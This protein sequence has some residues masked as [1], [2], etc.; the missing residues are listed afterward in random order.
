M[1]DRSAATDRVA[2][3]ALVSLL[4]LLAAPARLVGEGGAAIAANR[5]YAM[6]VAD[7]RPLHGQVDH[8]ALA[9]GRRVEVWPR[10]GATMP[11]LADAIESLEEGFALW[12]PDDRLILCNRRYRD[13]YSDF[14]D[15]T[16]PGVPFL[17]H[18][19]ARMTAP[20][21]RMPPEQ[22]EA[23][24]AKRQRERRQNLPPFEVER[25]DG[26]WIR[27][28]DRT[29]ADGCLV[30]IRIDVTD[31][32]RGE[33]HAAERS[34]ILQATLENMNDGILAFDS[35][36]RLIAW[37]DKAFRL[38]GLPD[39][40]K[41]RGMPLLDLVRRQVA[42]GE[43][44][45]RSFEDIYRTH[46]E[47]LA[48]A[49]PES[50][51]RRRPDGT[52]LRVRHSSASN[53]GFITTFT[54]VTAQRRAEEEA[55]RH[56]AILAAVAAAAARILSGESWLDQTRLLL[57]RAGEVLAA[58][59]VVLTEIQHDE[60]GARRLVDVVVWSVPGQE[61]P[62]TPMPPELDALR[63]AAFADWWDR[64]ERGETEQALSRDLDDAKRGFLMRIGVRSLLRMPVLIGDHVWGTVGLDD[65]VVE[66]VWHPIEVE[67][68]RAVANLVGVAIN[69]ERTE[70][71]RRESD[72]T[73][74]GLFEA[75]PDSIVITE[76]QVIV[77]ANPI[78]V[79]MLG[80]T[81]ASELIGRDIYDFVPPEYH[82]IA[83]LR[84]RVVRE[85]GQPA[86]YREREMLRVDGS[87]FVVET[88]GTKVSA[89]GRDRLQLI[90][91]DVTEK[92]RAAAEIQR[93]REALLQSEKLA[94]LGSLLAGVAHELNNPLSVVV[95]Q[96]FLMEETA[97]DD[98]TRARAAKI[99]GAADRCARIVKTFLAMARQRP[100]ERR[101]VA[102]GEVVRDALEIVAYPLRTAG[103]EVAVTVPDDLPTLWADPDQLGQVMMNLLLNAQQALME[104]PP[105]RRLAVTAVSLPGGQRIRTSVAD[106]GPGVDPD[107]R[108]RIFDPFFTT[109]PAGVGTGV[110]L[111]VCHGIVAGHDGTIWVEETPGG[112]ASFVFELPIGEQEEIAP[113]P[114]G[115]V[116][117]PA[118]GRSVL[119][120][121]DE[122]DIATMLEEI[123]DSAGYRVTVA[124]SGRAALGQLAA[125]RF[126]LVLS[127]IRMPDVDGRD[128]WRAVTAAGAAAGPIAFMTG[129]AL[130]AAAAE[131]LVDAGCAV[132][133]KPFAP[134][135]V[136]AFVARVLGTP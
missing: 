18:A 39:E 57:A 80:A 47:W 98:K 75:S 52:M 105:P 115:G 97:K 56:Q 42:E 21:V 24:V 30:S 66:R 113:A 9:D 15:L 48:R 99:R 127:D 102:L 100:P 55:D 69:R 59:R 118:V 27:L 84:A 5:P 73:Y 77:S 60:S 53:Q 4:D 128:L 10:A 112:G 85:S 83:R 61:P 35:E 43:F 76:N 17:D 62:P 37:N 81:S 134:S 3:E 95:G 51:E 32:K 125:G 136:V 88:T 117:A 93:Q 58:S 68:L 67:A 107:M 90:F 120:V 106:N 7:G 92:R 70:Q 1:N 74:R 122:P 87:R 72:E 29:M 41:R 111:S 71:A 110:G 54:D 109:K 78:A 36:H 8:V 91:R 11:V 131:F 20:Q 44:G 2:D 14:N 89:G 65:C 133:E 79:R 64:R 25:V 132:L 63:H 23:Y 121:D 46:S 34:R 38:A 26:R 13:L 104:V 86:P 33:A 45:E 101:R 119:V 40:M 96:S 124:D 19:R 129:D 114:A 126:D 123:L 103:V 130:G 116:A 31:L 94:A 108:R 50:Y 22:V 12:G 82:A 6:L 135:E 28:V 49:S 16:Y